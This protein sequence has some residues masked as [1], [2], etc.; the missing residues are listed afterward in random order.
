MIFPEIFMMGFVFLIARCFT[1]CFFVLFI[2]F[3]GKEHSHHLGHIHGYQGIWVM[4]GMIRA[5]YT[6]TTMGSRL[7]EGIM[8]DYGKGLQG[9]ELN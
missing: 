8:I 5:T 7:C 4:N 6:T 3:Y 9:N 1:A 2:G